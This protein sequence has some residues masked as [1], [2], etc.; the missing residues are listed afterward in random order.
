MLSFC[1]SFSEWIGTSILCFLIHSNLRSI[2]L[3]V[4]ITHICFVLWFSLQIRLCNRYATLFFMH[5]FLGRIF[6]RAFVFSLFPFFHCTCF[7]PRGCLPDFHR[8]FISFPKP[9]LP[10]DQLFWTWCLCVFAW[11]NDNVYVFFAWEKMNKGECLIR[12]LFLPPYP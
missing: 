5:I 10:F 9:I 2:V 11:G 6:S 7:T 8:N 12:I 4:A 1:Q 3:L